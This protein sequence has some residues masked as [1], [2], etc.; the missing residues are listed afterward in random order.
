MRERLQK[1]ISAAG[2]CSRR[3]AEKLIVDGK[4]CVLTGQQGRGRYL[5]FRFDIVDDAGKAIPKRASDCVL[6]R[7]NSGLVFVSRH[8]AVNS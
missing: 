1:L 5:L 7:H 3:T 8:D 2:I 4:V 6:L